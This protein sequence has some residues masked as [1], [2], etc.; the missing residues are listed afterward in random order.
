MFSLFLK[1]YRIGKWLSKDGQIETEGEKITDN[2]Y[3]WVT[4]YYDN[5]NIYYYGELKNG[6]KHGQ[7]IMFS[8][9]GDL[10]YKGEFKRDEIHIKQFP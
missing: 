4:L 5:S 8:S 9:E 7:G 1:K 6:M 2:L 10:Q 3:K